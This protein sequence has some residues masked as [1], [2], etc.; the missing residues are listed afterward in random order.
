MK[1]WCI[2][3]HFSYITHKNVLNILSQVL[4][5]LG[6]SQEISAMLARETQQSKITWDSLQDIFSIFINDYQFKAVIVTNFLRP[7]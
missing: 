7:S 4:P 1:Y 6:S 5:H 3:K 2:F